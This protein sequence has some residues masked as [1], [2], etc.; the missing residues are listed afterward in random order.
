MKAKKFLFCLLVGVM[1]ASPVALAQD[2]DV[3][4]LKEKIINLQN[5][6]PLGIRTL[7]ACSKVT[8]YG[9]YEPL[10]DNRVKSGD[11]IFFYFEPQNPSTKKAGGRYEMWLTQ[12]MFVFTAQQQEVFKKESAVEI[13]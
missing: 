12:D 3:S 2:T 13:H 6:Y 11:M 7:I 8:D 4:L 10:L 1:T 9:S 5:M